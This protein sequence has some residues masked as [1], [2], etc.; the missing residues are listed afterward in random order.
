MEQYM[1]LIAHD[2]CKVRMIE[3][4]KENLNFFKEYNLCATGTTGKLLE[5]NLNLSV[6]KLQ[7][8]PYGGDQQIGALI[9]EG[10]IKSMFFFWDPLS[11]HPHESDVKALLRLATLW[12]VPMACNEA[13]AR[14]II[15]SKNI[16]TKNIKP[17][18]FASSAV[19]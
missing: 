13:T 1:A 6:R 4:V 11:A 17:I 9:A 15:T 5:H 18:Y 12:N 7:S 19:S 2:A 10:K 16:I 3:F 14:Y 8:G